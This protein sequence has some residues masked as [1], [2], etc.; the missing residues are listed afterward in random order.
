MKTLALG[1]LSLHSN[2]VQGPLAGYSCSPFRVLTQRYGNPGFCSTEMISANT[3]VNRKQIPLR[4][5]HRDSEE[6]V[7]CYQL[8]GNDADTMARATAIATEQGADVID[9]NCGCPV[10]KIRSKG[11]GSRLL[12]TPEKLHQLVNAMRQNTDAAVSIKIRVAGSVNDHDDMAV[13]DAAEQAGVDFITVHGRHWTERYDVVSDNAAIARV[14][15]A[16]TVPV[17]AN[18]DVEDAA[19]FKN[20]MQETGCVGVMIARASVGQPWLFEKIRAELKGDVFEIPSVEQIGDILLEHIDRLI[21]LD[22][23]KLA[24]LQSRKLAK[25]YARELLDKKGFIMAMQAA[26]SRRQIE[27]I[28]SHFF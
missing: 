6:G 1:K 23:E 28:I 10:A 7:L 2:L 3:L 12:T 18:G 11:S 19:S 25:Y 13:I 26:E 17:L 22:S 27:Q 24:V 21:Q 8:S 9:L 15:K 4:Y 16:A 5:T 20:T 14:V